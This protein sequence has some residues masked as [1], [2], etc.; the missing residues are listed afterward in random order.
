MQKEEKSKDTTEELYKEALKRHKKYRGK[1][2]VI[3]KVP[4]KEYRDLGIYYTPGV[5][6]ASEVVSKDKEKVWELTNRYNY[7]AIVSDGTRVLGLGDIGPEA[8]LPVM[9]GKGFLFKALGGVDAFPI[10]LGTKNRDEIVKTVKYLQPGFGGVNLEDIES[11][12]C[13]YVLEKLQ[14]ELEIPVW[15]DDAQGT[16]LVTLGGLINALKVIGKK[17]EEVKIALLGAGAAGLTFVKFLKRYGFPT[18]NMILLDSHGPLYRGRGKNMNPWKKRYAKQTNPELLGKDLK[19]KP[20]EKADK[21]LKL[22]LEGADVLISASKPG[23]WLP[24]EY[25]EHM[26]DEAIVFSEANPVPEITPPRAKK[27]GAKIVATGRSDWSNQINNVLGFPAL[28]RG[29]LDVAAKEINDEM[30][31][32]A[33]IALAEAMEQELSEEYILPKADEEEWAPREAAAVAEAAIKSGSARIKKSKDEVYEHTKE[34]IA[35]HR[36]INKFIFNF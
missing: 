11:P 15:H 16:A 36:K 31:E 30:V 25:I 21:G 32:A 35:H 23:D 17:K 12:K 10:V 22:A 24:G 1:L 27:H 6:K 33:G 20:R 2:E 34:L 19:G 5:A 28:F 4:F 3:S 8:G 18:K 7:V 9:E 13:F 29:A 26:A 14:D